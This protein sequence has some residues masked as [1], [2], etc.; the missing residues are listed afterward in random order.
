MYISDFMSKMVYK[1]TLKT[2][3][4]EA[5]IE[6]ERLNIG[7]ILIESRNKLKGI[8]SERDLLKRVIAEKKDVNKILLKDVMTIDI[9]TVLE[10]EPIENAINIMNE[11]KIRHLPVVNEN[12]ACIG[13][14]GIKDIMEYLSRKRK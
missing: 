11:H 3:V 14:I 4:K 7:A 1:A 9:F 12:N 8:F 10:H 5:V 2:T 13:M 6:M